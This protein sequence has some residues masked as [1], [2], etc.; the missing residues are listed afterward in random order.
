MQHLHAGAQV[1]VKQRV[2]ED[3]LW[4]L[5]KVKPQTLLRPI[6][7]PPGATARARLSVRHVVKKAWYWSVFTNAKAGTWPTWRCARCCRPM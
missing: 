7:G 5:G 1:A 2:L 3:N 6:E 4:H